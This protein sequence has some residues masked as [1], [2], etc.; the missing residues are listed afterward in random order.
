MQMPNGRPGVAGARFFA[1]YHR[2][3]QFRGDVARGCVSGI[4]LDK[5]GMQ[6]S[7]IK[8][9]SSTPITAISSGTAMF[10]PRQMSRISCPLMS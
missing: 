1:R 6:S 2:V 7:Q 10:C 4:T 9:L 8:W 3:Q 5:G